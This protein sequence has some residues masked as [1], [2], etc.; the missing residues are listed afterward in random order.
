[1][2]ARYETHGNVAVITLDNPPVNGLGHATRSGVASGMERAN[3]DPS[4]DI[5]VLIGGGKVFSGGADIREFN[6]PK[7]TEEPRLATVIRA[8][9]ASGKPVVAAIRGVCMGGGL[10][11]ALGCHFRIAASDAGDRSA[12]GQARVASRGGRYAA[13]AARRRRRAGAADD[14][15]RRKRAGGT[16]RDTRLFDAIVEGRSARGCA[17]VRKTSGIRAPARV[18][19]RDFA[20][21]CPNLTEVVQSARAKAA[22]EAKGQPAPQRCI[23]AVAAAATMPF[24]EGLAF[25]RNAFEALVTTPESRAMRH[26][27]FA[28]R[29]AARIPGIAD[30]TPTRK[31]ASIAVI[32]AGTM[33]AGIAMNGLSAG[34]PVVLLEMNQEALERGVA[35]IRRNYQASVE[36]GKLTPEALAKHMALLRPTLAYDDLSG[37]DL[38]IEAVF[39][40]MDLKRE[41]F[42]QLDRVSKK[43]AILASNTSTL[44][45]NR[46]AAVTTRP[47]DVIG[48]HFF[49]PANIMKLLEV[50]RGERTGDD[51]LMTVM[52]LAKKIGKTAVVSG[53]CDGFIGNR[54]VE[55]YL[56]RRCSCWRRALH[57]GRWMP[58]WK[59]S[60]WRWARSG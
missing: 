6:T 55:Q 42:A 56:R 26:A 4:V 9:E 25:E 16:L 52:A 17:G 14:R 1:M 43:G 11:L 5:I 10:E 35:T 30:A 34:L 19:V 29:T 32:G 33:G 46:I 22:V 15:E 41:V 24:D 44:D 21:D 47:Q 28:E 36:R 13:V 57:R 60:G 12:R 7:A 37:T 59:T 58:R 48:M 49:S 39:E 20:I 2:T 38:V 18:R 23:D 31:I 53:V 51:V 54:M 50:V 3:A 45:L 27:F 8:A 40:E